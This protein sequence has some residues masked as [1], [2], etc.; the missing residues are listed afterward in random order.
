MAVLEDVALKLPT[1]AVVSSASEAALSLASSVETLE[2][3][4]IDEVVPVNLVWSAL[5]PCRSTPTRA[6]TMLS[7]SIPDPMPPKEIV[8]VIR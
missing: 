5:S 2:R 4:E 8:P 1:S 7:V 3:F 6:L